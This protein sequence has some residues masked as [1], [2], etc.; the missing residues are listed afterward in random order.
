M[1]LLF[2]CNQNLNRNKTAKEIFKYKFQT[3]SAGLYN[4]KPVTDI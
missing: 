2:V 1:K 4:E 3:K